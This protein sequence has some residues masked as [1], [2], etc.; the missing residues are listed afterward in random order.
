MDKGAH[1]NTGNY[2]DP[3]LADDIPHCLS[4]PIDAV[5]PLQLFFH[6]H[7]FTC[8][9][10][11]HTIGKEYGQ[12]GGHYEVIHHTQ[13]LSELTARKVISVTSDSPDVERITFHDPCYLGRM[14]GVIEEPRTVLRSTNAFVLEMPRH[15]SQSFCCG[16]GGAQMWKEEEHGAE[17]VNETRYREAAATGADTIAVG[18]PF[19]LTMMDDAA[20]SAGTG[21]KVKDVAEIIAERL[22]VVGEGVKEPAALN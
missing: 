20:K 18:C 22:V 1:P 7:R 13:L 5:A 6:H 21:M 3:H 17:K 14:N 9:H 4:A 10:C 16:A 8:P 11:L 2:I 15:G 12:F 19:C